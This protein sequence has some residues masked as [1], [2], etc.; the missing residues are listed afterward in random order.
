MILPESWQPRRSRHPLEGLDATRR[1]LN[2]AG[3]Q[4]P[5]LPQ[6]GRQPDRLGVRALSC[7]SADGS[8]T[9]SASAHS[10]CRWAGDGTA[11]GRGTV[12]ARS[13]FAGMPTS[14]R[15]LASRL[16]SGRSCRGGPP[17]PA[18]TSSVA[19]ALASQRLRWRC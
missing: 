16:C 4:H 8:L 9:G 14:E 7:R 15:V 12:V 18:V 19:C 10:K 5:H 1:G 2:P 17:A 13:A 3:R 11:A 6:R